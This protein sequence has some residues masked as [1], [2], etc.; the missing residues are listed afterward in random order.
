MIPSNSGLWRILSNLGHLLGGKAIAGLASLAYLVVV[1]RTLG[2][3]DF[4]LL[5]LLH[6]YVVLLGGLIAFSG[7][8]GLVRYGKIAME[9]GDFARLARI[10]RLMALIELVCGVTAILAAMIL[11]PIIGPHLGWPPEA[12]LFAVPYSVAVIAGVRA[13]PQGLLQIAGRF[14]LIGLHQTV[15]PLVRLVGTLWVWQSGGEFLQF[16][17]VWLIAAIA[18]CLVMWVL[19]LRVWQRMEAGEQIFGE[20]RGVA[21]ENDGLIRF[22]LTTNF[23][24]TLRELTPNLVPLTIGFFLGPAAAGV[25]GLVQRASSI[26]KQPA[27]LL[28]Q[29]SYAVLAELAVRRDWAELSGT[30][31]RG[32][33]LAL[34]ISVP[35]VLVFAFF[36]GELLELLGGESF[37]DG[38]TLLL[39]VAMG[40]ALALSFTPV[41]SALTA[42]G[43]PQRSVVS[44][45]ISEVA[46][47]PLLPLLLLT[48]GLNGA[49]LQILAQSAMAAILVS[50]FFVRAV[51]KST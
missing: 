37:A 28:S 21:K 19:A 35:V 29:A 3:T 18:E 49:G 48:A 23:D 47:Y 30:V 9:T 7:F 1:A 22:I 4:G 27:V 40:R 20:W 45:L 11:A 36:G 51:R 6:G 42:I 41:S 12:I 43:L 15:S 10:A 32:V 33:G 13:T 50:L 24:I 25:F 39:L 44:S 17:T 16:L 8:H 38:A 5:V 14:D 46:L 26:L 34:G 2:A 31:W